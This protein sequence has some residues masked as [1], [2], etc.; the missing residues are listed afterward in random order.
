MGDGL[1]PQKNPYL[2]LLKSFEYTLPLK[3]PS[4][5]T[6][7]S[8]AV[9]LLS[10]S[11][12]LIGEL[13]DVLTKAAVKAIESGKEK[14]DQKVLKEIDFIPPVARKWNTGLARSKAAITNA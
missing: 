11:E 3:K 8:I 13:S 12:G 1:P 4:N 5:L 14:I 2:Q 10:M 7:T 9:K 6:D